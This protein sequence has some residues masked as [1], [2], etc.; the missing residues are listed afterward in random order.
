MSSDQGTGLGGAILTLRL[1]PRPGGAAELAERLAALVEPTAALP[2]IVR[3][4]VALGVL[5]GLDADPTQPARLAARQP[6]AVALL[7][8]GT[9]VPPLQ[10]AAA[11]TLREQTLLAAGAASIPQ[12]G[13]YRMLCSVIG[14]TPARRRGSLSAGQERSHP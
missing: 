3:V 5:A 13:L 1:A 12:R 4:S 14:Q 11:E 9:D 6:D 8:E 7:V 10:R 2:G